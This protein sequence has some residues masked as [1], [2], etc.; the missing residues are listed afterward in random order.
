[1][2]VGARCHD[3]LMSVVDDDG[4]GVQE[5]T[6]DEIIRKLRRGGLIE[7]VGRRMSPAEDDGTA[8]AAGMMSCSSA[9]TGDEIPAYELHAATWESDSSAMADRDVVLDHFSSDFTD[10]D[11]LLFVIGG[12]GW[13]VAC[14]TGP[15]DALIPAHLREL[16]QLEL[17]GRLV[18][19]RPSPEMRGPVRTF[20]S[21]AA[22]AERLREIG[23][24]VEPLAVHESAELLTR[25]PDMQEWL[26][27]GEY[28]AFRLSPKDDLRRTWVIEIIVEDRWPSTMAQLAASMLNP[29]DDEIWATC[30]GEGWSLTVHA[31][32]LETYPPVLLAAELMGALDGGAVIASR[33]THPSLSDEQ[34]IESFS[35]FGRLATMSEDLIESLGRSL[36]DREHAEP[37][38]L[39]TAWGVGEESL[40]VWARHASSFWAQTRRAAR[41][42]PEGGAG[43]DTAGKA[44][45]RVCWAVLSLSLLAGQAP[46][47]DATLDDPLGRGALIR[48]VRS[49]EEVVG[50]RLTGS[51][52]LRRTLDHGDPG[53]SA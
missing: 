30:A 32:E 9:W 43:L 6:A 17:G 24:H 31:D 3:H 26:D 7:H 21:A 33:A 52:R 50:R 47:A 51:R 36:D 44:A 14:I 25:A 2:I 41:L 40:G 35:W 45:R 39:V 23:L 1:M 15:P 13:S 12:P 27:V 22:L 19:E 37:R 48:D 10:W 49:F 46:R 34:T 20:S 28:A 5:L 16:V 8:R 53:D 38:V 42:Q 11:R 29:P 18:L 4:L